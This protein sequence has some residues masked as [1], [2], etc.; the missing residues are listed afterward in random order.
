M[1][2]LPRWSGVLAAALV[3]L[4]AVA[5]EPEPAPAPPQVPGQEP[6]EP[7]EPEETTPASGAPT[8]NEEWERDAKITFSVRST[9]EASA[10]LGAPGGTAL[11][12][13]GAWIAL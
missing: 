1:T 6:E 13:A 5:Q 9:V 11:Y 8:W 3:A 2:R 10:A 12:R 4:G 7:A